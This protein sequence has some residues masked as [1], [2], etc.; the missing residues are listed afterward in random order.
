[1]RLRVPSACERWSSSAEP[2]YAPARWYTSPHAGSGSP[3]RRVVVEVAVD[4]LDGA[5]GHGGPHDV[6]A[7][8]RPDQRAHGL[9]AVGQRAH[10]RERR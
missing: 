2:R 7:R 1:M 6:G 5:R 3:Q 4:E 9:V 10:E 8:G